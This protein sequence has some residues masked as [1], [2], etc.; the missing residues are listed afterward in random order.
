MRMSSSATEG[1]REAVFTARTPPLT[2][3][4]PALVCPRARCTLYILPER[5]AGGWRGF[6]RDED[7]LK[8][9]VVADDRAAELV[10]DEFARVSTVL[11]T[12]AWVEV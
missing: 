9:L 4:D 11:H 8:E 6:R 10:A 12:P 3:E 7:G 1:G 2:A 5:R